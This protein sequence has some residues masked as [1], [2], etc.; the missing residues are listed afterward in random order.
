VTMGAVETNQVDLE[1][2]RLASRLRG[3][4]IRPDGY[5]YD[6]ARGVHNTAIDRRP[7]A[8]V[9]VAEAGDVARTIEMARATGLPLAVRSGGHSIAG[10][11]TVDGGLVIDLALMRNLRIDRQRGRALAQAGLTAGE[12]T[13]ALHEDGLAVPLGDT[14]SVGLGGLTLGGG[15]GWLVRRHG[16][17]VDSL[18]SVEI[19]TAGG[20]VVTASAAEHPDLFWALRGGGGNFGVATRFE[21][22]THALDTVLGGAIVLPATPEM[23]RGVVTIALQA[24]DE[25]TVIAQVMHAPPAPYVPA[26]QVGRLVIVVMLVYAGDPARGAQVI[27]P[28]RELAAPI[29]DIVRPMGYPDIYQLTAPA[30]VPGPLTLRSTYLETIDPVA[31]PIIE[32][33]ESAPSTTAMTQIRILGGAAARV[34]SDATAYGFRDRP[35]LLAIINPYR[36]PA[37]GERQAGWTD[38]CWAAVRPHGSG[39]L[40]SFLGDEGQARVREAYPDATYER[41]AAVKRRY[42][43]DNLFRLNQN[44]LP[45]T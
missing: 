26:D 13:T 42:D 10:H 22:R 40:S 27:R 3:R 2:D 35:L 34:P 24:P 17:T 14:T 25:L 36:D 45:A 33:L 41:L 29:A 4:M 23:L 30:S 12:L 21:Y 1:L 44:I 31:A 8:I 38:E 18:E 7:A 9:R 5:G 28:L 20:D 16:L 19:V 32:H 11:G 43:P 37:D 6:D 39:V 15:V